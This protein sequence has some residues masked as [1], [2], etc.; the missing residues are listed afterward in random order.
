MPDIVG[1]SFR[2]PGKIYH[3]DPQG[4]PI[5]RLDQIVAETARGVE[6]GT[7]MTDVQPITEEDLLAP[8]KKI[9]RFATSEDLRR[10]QSYRQREKDAFSYSLKCIA[11]RNLP[12]KL[13][14]TEYAF[15]GSQITFYFVSETRVD[16]RELVKDLASHLKCKIQLYQIGARDQ[17]KSL[18]GYGVCGRSLCCATFLRTFDPI[19]MKMAKEQSLFLNP[20]KFS[21]VCGKLMCCLRYEYD[22]YREARIRMPMISQVV[23]TPKG[24]ARVQSLNVVKETILAEF[25][26]SGTVLEFSASAVRWEQIGGKC[27]HDRGGCSKN[28][29]SCGRTAR[30][31][32][33]EED[34]ID[35][36]APDEDV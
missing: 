35:E 1:V 16:F 14:E 22:A 23:Q 30:S 7:A 12:M 36:D 18:G 15:D 28:G 9:V 4:L 27:G 32:A 6:I 21:G 8:L 10:K 3:F 25:E 13:V 34:I 24:Q 5:R 33:D 11:A 31:A 29:G 2:R 26:E 19:S 17:A 20:T